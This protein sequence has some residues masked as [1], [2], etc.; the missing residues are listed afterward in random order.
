MVYE[1]FI[2]SELYQKFTN[3]YSS[4]F[5]EYYWPRVFYDDDGNITKEI[6]F[7]EEGFD[8][9]LNKTLMAA[10][11]IFEI[12][13]EKRF[14]IS[15]MSFDELLGMAGCN[16]DS[17]IYENGLYGAVFFIAVANYPKIIKRKW[18]F[19]F[20]RNVITTI[21]SWFRYNED[22]LIWLELYATLDMDITLIQLPDELKTEKMLTYWKKLQDKGLIDNRYQIIYIPRIKNYHVAAIANELR[23]KSGV[24]WETLEKHFLQRNN[25][26]FANLRTECD[27]RPAHKDDIMKTIEECFK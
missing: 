17:G 9:S 3:W 8:S 11:R 20:W 27:R 19:L 1:T 24:K 18:G 22:R 12:A 26:P 21:D 10:A 2:D 4:K 16:D 6:P 7:D 23:I 25:K 13:C 5:I 15:D 14:L